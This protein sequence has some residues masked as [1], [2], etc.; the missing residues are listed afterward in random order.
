MAEDGAIDGE[1]EGSGFV[2]SP[3]VTLDELLQKDSEDAAMARYKASLL[4]AAGGGSSGSADGHPRARF[5]SDPRV[6][7][8]D[9][10]RIETD[11]DRPPIVIDLSDRALKSKP[12]VLKEGTQF[13]V[14]LVF[15]VQHDLV[16]GLRWTSSV[17]KYGVCVDKCS[18]MLGSF[19]PSNR[20]ITHRLP[21]EEA[22][23][24]MLARGS[25]TARAKLT[26]DDGR[27]HAEIE[28]SFG[29]WG[30]GNT[31]DAPLAHQWRRHALLRHLL[32]RLVCSSYRFSPPPL[33]P[34]FVC[35]ALLPFLSQT[36]RRTGEMLLQGPAPTLNH[37]SSFSPLCSL[38]APLP[39]CCPPPALLALSLFHSA[40]NH[41]CFSPFSFTAFAPSQQPTILQLG[42][43]RVSFS[44]LLS[45]SR[46]WRDSA[47]F[48]NR[49]LISFLN[50]F[51][52]FFCF[53]Y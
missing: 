10:V 3:K 39:L 44:Q 8:L 46:F 12:Y 2:L 9:S 13:S 43:S 4:G 27:T 21:E 26:D 30:G 51:L 40:R 35:A 34:V 17:H 11:E 25:F 42:C 22:P 14:V 29:Q 19:A 41:P 50:A 16:T 52:I 38:S 53:K 32:H 5:P 36:L 45:I 15:A 33:D 6:V 47:P 48:L 49:K 28:Y 37:S 1:V 24:G 31:N 7:V 20:L 18:E 23:S